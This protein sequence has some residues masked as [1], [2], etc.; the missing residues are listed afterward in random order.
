[1]ASSHIK[2]VLDWILGKFLQWKIYQALEQV[3]KGLRSLKV[4]RS[5][6][7]KVLRIG[8]NA[9]LGSGGLTV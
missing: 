4:F 2:K 6:I 7:N 3:V 5:L 1:M 9:G 8:F